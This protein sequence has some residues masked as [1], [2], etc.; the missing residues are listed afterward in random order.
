[1]SLKDYKAKNMGSYHVPRLHLDKRGRAYCGT[2]QRDTLKTTSDAKL[3]TC[4]ACLMKIKKM[5][6]DA[7]Q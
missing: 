6:K 2:P 7:L 3:V 4:V 1:M 5:S